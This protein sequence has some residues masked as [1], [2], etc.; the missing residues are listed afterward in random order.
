MTAP[1]IVYPQ[2]ATVVQQDG[3]P[4]EQN[5]SQFHTFT[6]STRETC[7]N[8][9][10]FPTQASQ[11]QKSA[12]Q[13]L[14]RGA[15]HHSRWVKTSL[16]WWEASE[17]FIQLWFSVNEMNLSAFSPTSFQFSIA[18]GPLLRK[19]HF[20]YLLNYWLTSCCK[21]LFRMTGIPLQMQLRSDGSSVNPIK[22]D[23]E[24]LNELSFCVQTAPVTWSTW[25]KIICQSCSCLRR[26]DRRTWSC[27]SRPRRSATAF[28]LAAAAA[29]PPAS[30]SPRQARYAVVLNR[31]ETLV[32]LWKT[33]RKPFLTTGL[34]SAPSA[35][36]TC[37]VAPQSGNEVFVSAAGHTETSH[38]SSQTV[39]QV[40]KSASTSIGFVVVC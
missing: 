16:T 23:E 27:S 37:A 20:H 12:V 32:I 17:H 26:T 15:H 18:R 6:V 10:R 5:R 33:S 29:P 28:W 35:S 8:S 14:I 30:P 9:H 40:R 11:S 38:I 13:E 25:S 39:S 24:R 19:E 4:L 34:S 7:F 3:Q 31:S 22:G 36:S 21:F 1:T 2:Q